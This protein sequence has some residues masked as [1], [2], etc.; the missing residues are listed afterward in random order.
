[1]VAVLAESRGESDYSIYMPA[2]QV[3]S[4]NEWV[5]GRRINRDKD[6]YQQ[7]AVKVSDVNNWTMAKTDS[8]RK[9]FD[10]STGV[11]VDSRTGG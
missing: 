1:V 4:L 11:H 10:P 6:G 7:L 5:L 9:C 2:D 8:R 3:Q